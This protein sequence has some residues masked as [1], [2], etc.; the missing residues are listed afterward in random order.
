MLI[1]YVEGRGPTVDPN[2]DRRKKRDADGVI[3]AVTVT[4]SSM[5]AMRNMFQDRLADFHCMG[6]NVYEVDLI[7]TCK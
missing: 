3:S 6:H 5:D 4:A 2:A 1:A 7:H